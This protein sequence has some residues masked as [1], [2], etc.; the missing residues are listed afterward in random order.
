[1]WKSEKASVLLF[2]AYGWERK[3]GN[4]A[5]LARAQDWPLFSQPLSQFGDTH[6]GLS[7][8]FSL[9]TLILMA[10]PL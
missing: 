9:E 3:M 8:A 5:N 4:S 10:W 1:M 7:R 2:P 6:A